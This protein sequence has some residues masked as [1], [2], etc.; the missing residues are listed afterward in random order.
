MPETPT[1]SDDRATMRRNKTT[2]WHW[3]VIAMAFFVVFNFSTL[4]DTVGGPIAY[5]ADVSGAVTLYSTSWCGYCRKARR[6]L[7]KHDIPFQELDVEKNADASVAF[8]RLG[9][10][11]VPVITVGDRIVH[12]FNYGRLRT[13]LECGDCE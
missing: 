9:G 4:R 7:N 3:G 12:G 11:G 13:L 8:Q 10:R 5:S 1:S 2:L 6:M